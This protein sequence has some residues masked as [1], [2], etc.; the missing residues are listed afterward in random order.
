MVSVVNVVTSPASL[1]TV[2]M[3]F[4]SGAVLGDSDPALIGPGR[5]GVTM[6]TPV[7]PVFPVF[8]SL[9]VTDV[10]TIRNNELMATPR[11][12][13]LLHLISRKSLF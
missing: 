13:I 9:R 12:H 7:I 1:V 4:G 10:H 6:I 11:R 5:I 3:A 8:E 2:N